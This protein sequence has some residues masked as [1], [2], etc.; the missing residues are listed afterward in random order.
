[1][2]VVFAYIYNICT[3]NVEIAELKKAHTQR[4]PTH[5]LSFA[6]LPISLTFSRAA[7]SLYSYV[8]ISL[9]FPYTIPRPRTTASCRFSAEERTMTMAIAASAAGPTHNRYTQLMRAG[10]RESMTMDTAARRGP[11]ELSLDRRAEGGFD[12]RWERRKGA[13]GLLDYH[14]LR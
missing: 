3:E 1:M 10:W 6:A 4:R 11:G 9:S 7:F 14:L 13:P 8:A 12:H 5:N 2:S